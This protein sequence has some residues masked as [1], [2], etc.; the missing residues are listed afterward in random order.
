[1]VLL[2]RHFDVVKLEQW[3]VVVPGNSRRSL[4][5]VTRTQFTSALV[6]MMEATIWA[7][8]TLRL[9]GIA[10]FAIKKTVLVPVGMRVLMPWAMHPKSFA[11][12]LIHM[13]PLGTGMRCQYLSAWPLV[14]SMT[15]LAC[16]S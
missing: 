15:I 4:P 7:Y 3:V 5:T 10:D 8:V 9:W 12:A 14:G 6:G 16:S 13:S 2:S 11:S 1:M